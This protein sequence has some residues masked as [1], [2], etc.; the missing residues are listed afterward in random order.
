[1]FKVQR[2]ANGDVVLTVIGDLQADCVGELS[3]LLSEELAGQTLTLDLKSLVL[4]DRPAVHF[5][6]QCEAKGITLRNCPSYIRVWMA[7]RNENS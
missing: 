4:A 1:M 5:L 6:R 7:S 3:A 2:I